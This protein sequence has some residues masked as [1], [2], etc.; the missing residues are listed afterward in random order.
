MRTQNPQCAH[1]R[2]ILVDESMSGPLV[3][4]TTPPTLGRVAKGGG[5]QRLRGDVSSRTSGRY[6]LKVLDASG[7]FVYLLFG[8]KVGRTSVAA[9]RLILVSPCLIVRTQVVD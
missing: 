4:A 2:T 1:E 6:L 8:C 7:Q 3:L 5:S 9:D